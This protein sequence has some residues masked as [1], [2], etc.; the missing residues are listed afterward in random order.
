M[1]PVNNKAD[2]FSFLGSLAKTDPSVFNRFLKRNVKV[3][4]DKGKLNYM[5]FNVQADKNIASGS[6]KVSY[7]NLHLTV[8]RKKSSG[9]KSRFG[10][11]LV[12]TLTHKN[13]PTRKGRKIRT[14]KIHY[15]REVKRSIFNYMWKCLLTGIKSSIKL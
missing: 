12:N 11:F 6:M 10:T 5:K 4:I 7:N 9:R 2:R 3:K 15:K 13:N 1:I 14:G 8:M